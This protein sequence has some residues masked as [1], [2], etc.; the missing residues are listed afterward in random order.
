MIVKA[1]PK[2]GGLFIPGFP[3]TAPD[4][5]EEL[6][7]NVEVVNSELSADATAQAA[8]PAENSEAVAGLL[9]FPRVQKPEGMTLRDMTAEGRR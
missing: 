8:S 4:R 9:R 1:L 6:T 2:D 5:N 3:F 7:L